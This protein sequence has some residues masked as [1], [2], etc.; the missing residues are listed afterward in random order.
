MVSASS[1]DDCSAQNRPRKLKLVSSKPSGN[2][3]SEIS[4]VDT[5]LDTNLDPAGSKI[6]SKS[7]SRS[8]SIINFGS[9]LDPNL[10]PDPS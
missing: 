7:G 2:E 4:F 3:D 10:N 5:D 8:E 9:S 1:K 6:I